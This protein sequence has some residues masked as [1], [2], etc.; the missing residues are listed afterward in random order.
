M[1]TGEIP[2]SVYSLSKLEQ[3][4]LN[5]NQ[6]EGKLSPAVGNLQELRLIQLYE[7][8][9]TQKPPK[10]TLNRLTMKLALLFSA[11]S[12]SS[13]RAYSDNLNEEKSAFL[14][15]TENFWQRELQGSVGKSL[16]LCK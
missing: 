8:S 1:I 7:I 16:N 9:S 11:I 2:N 3:L 10:Q 13:A 14:Q 4:D 5:S 12:A 6:I 15:E